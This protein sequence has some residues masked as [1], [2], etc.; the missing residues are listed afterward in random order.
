MVKGIIFDKDGTL[1]DYKAFWYKVAENAICLLLQRYDIKN[2][3]TESLMKDFG[4]YD[5]ITSIFYQG[6]YGDFAEK[7][8]E[9]VAEYGY[10]GISL[11]RRE[12]EAAYNDSVSYGK[13]IPAC[14]KLQE[15]F[16]RLKK[17]NIK[18]AVATA[19]EPRMT[20]HCL[21]SLNISEYIDEIYTDD[22][23]TPAKPDPYSIDS[24]CQSYNLKREEIIMVGD[25]PLDM[26]FAKNGGVKA[27]GV[28]KEACDK[29]IL[30]ESA[31][32]V[33]ND[34]SEIFSVIGS[35]IGEV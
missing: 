7:F 27:V 2:I 16:Q 14:D 13:I 23:I 9:S 30:G 1:L 20:K 10:N 35:V 4:A 8:N 19:D 5:G 6:T 29:K 31:D 11:T 28:A 22:G 26:A 24:F 12:A 15:V 34:V 33:L 32:I 17:M 3:K 25:T 21:D 18:M